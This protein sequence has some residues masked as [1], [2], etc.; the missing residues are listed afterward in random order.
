[1]SGNKNKFLLIK[2]TFILTI[3]GIITRLLG[4]LFRIYITKKMGSECI[5]LY[6]LIL[7]IYTLAWSI[8][9]AG[10]TTAISKITA[11]EVAKNNFANTKLIL[12]QSLFLSFIISLLLNLFLYFYSRTFCIHIFNDIRLELSLKILS[13]AFIFMSLGSCLRGFFIGMQKSFV[14]AISQIIEQIIHMSIIYFFINKIPSEIKYACALAVL[15]MTVGEF[16]SFVYTY[17]AYKKFIFKNKN[18]S[19]ANIKFNSAFYLIISTA[20]PLSANKI[21]NSCLY[22]LENILIPKRLILNGFNFKNAISLYGKITGMA[23]PLVYFPSVFLISLAVSIVPEVSQAYAKKNQERIN[24]TISKT[25][26]L[27]SLIGFGATFFFMAFSHELG[28]FIYKQNI[29][30]ILKFL[31]L[32]APLIYLQII[33]SGILNGLGKQ[34]FVFKNNLIASGIN[35]F[36]I[37][38]IIPYKGITAFLFGWFLSLI[39]ACLLDLNIITKSINIKLR[40]SELILKPFF[41]V[42]ISGAI[43]K[44]FYKIFILKHNFINNIYGL[45]L[46][47]VFFAVSYIFFIIAIGILEINEIKKIFGFKS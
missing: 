44:L 16:F 28:I 38:F 21:I 35:L 12:N 42:F 29:S 6:Q 47:A 24:N 43:S 27:T 45:F 36:F 15:G 40:F 1:M 5:G 9:C 41:A 39:I 37:Y 46:C 25:I 22:T 30:F 8:S 23:M 34:I 17:I 20:L 18:K 32:M 7:P 2:S 31:G 26:L 11:Q 19:Q 13:C 14:P 10:L 4:F 33:L 3:S